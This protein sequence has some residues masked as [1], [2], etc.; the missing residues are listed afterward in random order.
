MKQSIIRALTLLLVGVVVQPAWATIFV[1]RDPADAPAVVRVK[2]SMSDQRMKQPRA[3]P[4]GNKA[5]Q[6]FLPNRSSSRE[7][8]SAL[9]VLRPDFTGYSSAIRSS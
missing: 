3:R 1:V 9:P 5:I 4:A 2:Q 7:R 8:G 6:S